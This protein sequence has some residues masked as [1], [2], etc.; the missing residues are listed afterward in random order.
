MAKLVPRLAMQFGQLQQ[1]AQQHYQQLHQAVHHHCHNLQTQYGKVQG[2]LSTGLRNNDV[3]PKAALYAVLVVVTTIWLAIATG[4]RLRAR[5]RKRDTPPSTPNL[6]K[7]SP[8]K[9]PDRPP[10]GNT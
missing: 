5:I 8:F 3:H 6:E 7:R 1:R 2:N 10:G 4:R 9:A